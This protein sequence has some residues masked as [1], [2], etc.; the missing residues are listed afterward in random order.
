MVEKT[1]FFTKITAMRVY[2]KI[3]RKIFDS[4]IIFPGLFY[5]MAEK[6]TR[7]RLQLAKCLS[8]GLGML[9]AYVK[10]S[11]HLSNIFFKLQLSC[12]NFA[13]VTRIIQSWI[14]QAFFIRQERVSVLLRT[15]HGVM[16]QFPNRGRLKRTSAKNL[17]I[18]C[19]TH[20]GNFVT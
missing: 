19:L 1:N 13:S 8:A 6:L 2:A 15:F 12:S 16:R 11:T 20:Q 10:L 9:P 18:K 14:H 7:S 3:I 17:I 5:L 4:L